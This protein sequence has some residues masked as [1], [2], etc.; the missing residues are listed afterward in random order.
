MFLVNKETRKN[1]G[2]T[3]V[4][5]VITI[6]ILIILAVVAV[7]AVFGDSGLLKYA[8]D[9]EQYQSNADTADAEVLNE[10]T[11]YID[12]IITGKGG[13]SG[14]D[15][16]KVPTTVEEA[17]NAGGSNVYFFDNTAALKDGQNNTVKVPGGFGV[18]KDSGINVEDGVVIEDR[19][20]NQFVWIP[21][22][23]YNTTDTEEATKTNVLSRRSWG[24]EQNVV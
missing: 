18:S 8:Q 16:T 15:D 2:I 20:G 6:V 3:L 1:G 23:T 12:G 21:V 14:G 5:L 10:A 22:G 4:A 7:N 17:K 19:N 11:S 9:A 24:A 13:S